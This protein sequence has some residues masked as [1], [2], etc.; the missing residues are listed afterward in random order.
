MPLSEYQGLA[1]NTGILR[2]FVGETVKAAFVDAVGRIWEVVP[3]GHAIVFGGFER[4]GDAFAVIDP[5]TVAQEIAKRKT[6][7]QA[8]I[9]DLKYLV[10]GIDV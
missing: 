8:R 4:L 6:E 2:F 5:N 1:N 10:P 3:S 9:Q 7:I